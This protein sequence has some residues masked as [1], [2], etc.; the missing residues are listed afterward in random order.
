[1][2]AKRAKTFWSAFRTF[3]GT[4]LEPARVGF[5]T[6]EKRVFLV[7]QNEMS[8][9]AVTSSPYAQAGLGLVALYTIYSL[10]FKSSPTIEEK[11][12][13]AAKKIKAKAA[14]WP[15][16][17]I[18]LFQFARGETV[19]SGSPFCCKAETLLKMAGAR[20][21]NKYGLNSDLP[22]AKV[23][24]YIYNGELYEDSQLGYERLVEAGLVKDLDA[25]LDARQRAIGVAFRKMIEGSLVPVITLERWRDNWPATRDKFFFT[26]VPT[27]IRLILGRVVQPGV[28]TSLWGIGVSRFT[29]DE[30][31]NKI[32]P[33]NFA[34]ISSQLGA[35]HDYLVGGSSPSSADAMLFGF[36]ATMIYHAEWS[37]KTAKVLLWA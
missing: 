5:Y 26:T 9:D 34:A 21:E 6:S 35:D 2:I 22:K 12:A 1:M 11:T 36:L 33:E 29:E 10:F 8:L 13:A 3:N 18:I 37:P 20:Y 15:A 17:T 24:A 23:P 16:D 31:Y 27:P 7:S 30:L 19:P 25:N 28:L 14:A 4:C 32:V